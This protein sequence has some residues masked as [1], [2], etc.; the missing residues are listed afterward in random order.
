MTL[1]NTLTEKLSAEGADLVAFANLSEL[2]D[3]VRPV[4]TNAVLIGV[5]LD[6]AIINGIRQGPTKAYYDLYNRVNSLLAR[7]T[8]KGAG[9]LREA[10][11]EATPIPPTVPKEKIVVE[12]LA[13]DFSHKM[14]ATRAG[15]GWVG[16]CALV[17]TPEYGSAIRFATVL[18]DGP[19]PVG[20][21][22]DESQCGVCEE[23]TKV[24]PGQAV[25]GK[26]WRAGMHRDAFFDAFGC[27]RGILGHKTDFGYICGMCIAVCPWTLRYLERHGA[28]S[29]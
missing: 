27:V 21:P 16:K 20:V 9:I 26:E 8:Q 17:V 23:C 28:F 13:A 12:T 19:L 6:P 5:A 29:L 10:G 7:L 15:V 18:T 11:H 4:L 3:D 22:I 14:A 25:S 24:C 1:A 2:P